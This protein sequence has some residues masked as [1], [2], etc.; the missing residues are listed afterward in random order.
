MTTTTNRPLGDIR[1]FKLPVDTTT[2][3]SR[4]T[5]PGVFRTIGLDPAGDLC[6]WYEDDPA[7]T[8]KPAVAYVTF[9][10]QRVPMG[11]AVIGSCVWRGLV[12]HLLVEKQR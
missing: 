6:V 7:P 9:T 8:D 5:A 4:L 1:I 2:V 12:W 10:G 11:F 3:P